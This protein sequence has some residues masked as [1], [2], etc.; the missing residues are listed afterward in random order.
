[1]WIGRT[2]DSQWLATCSDGH[3][4]HI[5]ELAQRPYQLLRYRSTDLIGQQLGRGSEVDLGHTRLD[6]DR[7]DGKRHVRREPGTNRRCQPGIRSA[8]QQANEC[9]GPT[10]TENGDQPRVRNQD[11]ERR[12]EE[13]DRIGA[14]RAIDVGTGQQQTLGQFSDAPFAIDLLECET[15]RDLGAGIAHLESTDLG[16]PPTLARPEYDAHRVLVQ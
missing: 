6:R 10:R 4:R 16:D 15:G 3:I 13:V 11:V 8:Q 5:G 12:I 2:R 7:F 9:G 1:M 14:E